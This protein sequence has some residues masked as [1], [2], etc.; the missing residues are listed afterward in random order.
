[1]SSLKI[2]QFSLGR[3][4][5]DSYALLVDSKIYVVGV[6]SAVDIFEIKNSTAVWLGS[7]SL[8][9]SNAWNSGASAANGKLLVAGPFEHSWASLLVCTEI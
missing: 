3:Q 6:D 9:D 5:T 2:N 4:Y 1:M 7:K 8:G